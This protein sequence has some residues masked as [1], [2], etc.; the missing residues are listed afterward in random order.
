MSSAI[1]PGDEVRLR[2]NQWPDLLMTGSKA[3]VLINCI[4]QFDNF[5]QVSLCTAIRPGDE[6]RLRQYQWPDPD[7][8]DIR[9]LLNHYNE[10]DHAILNAFC[11][12][13]AG[14]TGR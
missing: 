3:M 1:R 14:R 6:L 10:V 8:G 12:T 9:H 4:S 13:S 7:D 2:Q 5:P 11:C